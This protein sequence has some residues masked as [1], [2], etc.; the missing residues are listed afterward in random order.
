MKKVLAKLTHWYEYR[1]KKNAKNNF[2]KYF[3]KLVND[4]VFGETME[5]VKKHK[6]TKLVTTEARKS[7]LNQSW[8]IN[9]FSQNLLSTEMKKQQILMNNLNHLDLWILE[10]SKTITYEF[11]HDYVK[12]KYLE[13]TKLCYMWFLKLWDRQTIT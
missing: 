3:F 6:N 7:Y 11:W 8:Y 5:N 13:Y 12:P 4:E 10:I 1:A 9:F 2:E